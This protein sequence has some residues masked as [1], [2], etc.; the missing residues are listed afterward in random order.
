[1]ATAKPTILIVDDTP[2]SVHILHS[3]LRAEYRILVAGNGQEALDVAV[4]K[5]PVLILLDIRMPG[6]DGFAVCAELKNRPESRNT[7]ILFISA[8]TNQE[9][10]A[11]ALDAG[12]VDFITKPFQ[13]QEV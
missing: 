4:T 2:E 10:K 11:H 8:L 7:P 13:V 6:M 3:I 1:M 5:N 9:D 12:G